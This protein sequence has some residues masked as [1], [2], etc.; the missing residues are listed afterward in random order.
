MTI[1]ILSCK[2]MYLKCRLWNVPISASI[3]WL[4]RFD[5]GASILESLGLH[6][7][8]KIYPTAIAQTVLT[9]HRWDVNL[10]S[11]LWFVSTVC[12]IAVDIIRIQS[13]L[14]RHRRRY[15]HI[16]VRGIKHGIREHSCSI[17]YDDIPYPRYIILRVLCIKTNKQTICNCVW[18][19]I[20]NS[21]YT[22]TAI[23]LSSHSDNQ[24]YDV[25]KIIL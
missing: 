22:V 12:A 5:L 7:S 25:R 9:N 4:S 1:Q 13:M 20:S 6:G 16:F 2:K 19:Y 15:G 21:I 17:Q 18:L 3:Y 24:Q 11:H 8:P 10:T 14:H 23:Y